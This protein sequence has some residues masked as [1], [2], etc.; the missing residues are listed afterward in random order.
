MPFGEGGMINKERLKGTFVEL[1]EIES[2]SRNEK[3]VAWYLTRI[4]KD[5]L[6]HRVIEDDSRERT[7]SDTGNLIVKINGTTQ[8]PPLLFNAH[9]D[10]VGPVKGIKVIYENGY[11]H[12]DGTTILGGDDKAAIAILIEIARCIR[13]KAI[14]TPPLEFL[15]TVCEEVG[16]LGAKALD[17]QLIEA[18]SGY[19]LDT[20][21]TFNLVNMAPTAIRFKIKV[22]GK[23]AHAGIA[24]E[25]GVNA[26]RLASEAI[27]KVP[28]GRI[29]HETTS[30]IGI[31]HGG[32]ATNIV[33]DLVE[34]EGEVRSHDEKKLKT[35]QDRIFA[36]FHQLRW[37]FTP[38]E[39]EPMI[40]IDVVDDYPL[41]K[42]HEGHPLVRTAEKAAQKL[43]RSLDIQKTG[44]GSDANILCSKGIDTVVLGIGMEEVH[45]TH[46]RI[47]LS[48]MV[49]SAEFIFEI[50]RQWQ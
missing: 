1:C 34:I 39:W 47:A 19:A 9:M 21:G 27:T 10:T 30:N 16:L 12:T 33:P 35:V 4:F 32:K 48:N 46:E 45:T 38:K 50:I 26:I 20:T 28:L 25:Q 31:I 37:S 15:F 8:S 29:D 2:P 18:S 40:Q 14:P 7:G 17:P 43:G 11:F 6:G 3:G 22:M 36:R 41:L 5:E 24:P 13:E 49:D 44:G 23:S 42:V